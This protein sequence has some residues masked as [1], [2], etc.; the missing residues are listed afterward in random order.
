MNLTIMKKIKRVIILAVL[1]AMAA[2]SLQS[3]G[4]LSDP[5][6][7]EGFRQGW[8]STVAPEYRY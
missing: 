6:F 4:L 3:C 1:F 8:N 2:M 5:N 7:H